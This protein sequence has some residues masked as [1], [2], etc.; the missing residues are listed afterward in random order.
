[1]LA[2]CG[3]FVEIH[4]N[5]ISAMMTQSGHPRLPDYGR[6]DTTPVLDMAPRSLPSPAEIHRH[7]T[8]PL[9]WVMC[10]LAGGSAGHSPFDEVYLEKGRPGTCK[11]P[12]TFQKLFL[13]N[14]DQVCGSIPCMYDI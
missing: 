10:H 2:S 9:R 7:K 11:H 12:V 14:A 6:G 4:A 8:S 13:E 1:M 5:V 3:S